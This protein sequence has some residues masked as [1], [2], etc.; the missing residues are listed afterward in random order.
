[1]FH[2]PWWVDRRYQHERRMVL[3]LGILLLI[4]AVV[5]AYL[6]IT[7]VEMMKKEEE[8]ESKPAVSY[9]L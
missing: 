1:M 4:A 8:A 3:A 7:K 5:V 2:S 9:R 6:G